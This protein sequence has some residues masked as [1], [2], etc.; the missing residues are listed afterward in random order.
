[1]RLCSRLLVTRALIRDH[2]MELT[3]SMHVARTAEELLQSRLRYAI[4][5]TIAIYGPFSYP[6]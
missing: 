3:E 2:L 1:M 6:T 4:K 5:G